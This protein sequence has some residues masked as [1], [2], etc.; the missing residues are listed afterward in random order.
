MSNDLQFSDVIIV[1]GGLSGMTAA[2]EINKK[3][4]GKL[5]I[6]VFEARGSFKIKLCKIIKFSGIRC[7]LSIRVDYLL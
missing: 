5:K 2:Y 4:C 6:V 7:K 3:S 1:G